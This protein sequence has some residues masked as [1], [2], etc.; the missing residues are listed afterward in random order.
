MPAHAALAVVNAVFALVSGGFA[1]AAALRPAVLAH[2][3]VTSAAS[4]YAW[5]YA[6]RAIPLT[7]AVV[8]LP[9]LGDRSGLVAILLVSGA[10]QAADVAIGAAQRNWGMTTGAAV[11]AA[12]HF[13]SAW[14]LAVH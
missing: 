8:I 6:A 10:V 13:G 5:M 11:G 9:T 7:I 1:I 2:G 4:L 14:W 12:V 3:P